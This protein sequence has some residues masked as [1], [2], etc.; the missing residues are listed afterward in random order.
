MAS[1]AFEM[2]DEFKG[3]SAE[4]IAQHYLETKTKYDTLDTEYKTYKGEWDARKPQ[5]DEYSAL[6][7]PKTVNEAI[8]WAREVAAPMVQKVAKGEAY[9]LN[10]ADYKAYKNWSEKTANGT[11]QPAQDDASDELFK[12]VEQ[13]LTEKLLGLMDERI[14]TRASQFDKNFSGGM[15]ALQDQLNL[16]AKVQGMQTKNPGVNFDDLLKRG[17]ELANAAPDQLLEQLLSMEVEKSSFD[18]R[19]EAAVA[20]KLA[21]KEVGKDNDV[22][23]AL[24]ENRRVGM[25]S[26]AQKPTRENTLRTLVAAL[27]KKDPG[28]LQQ[29][30]LA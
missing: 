11:R 7:E 30:P 27:N 26:T 15:K 25:N 20:A 17:A 13:R 5:W 6:G 8:K 3:K 4:E 12:P 19:L 2:P 21:E 18:Q 9:L 28:I 14:N 1:A 22:V 10:D 23:K 16:F 29:M 24:M